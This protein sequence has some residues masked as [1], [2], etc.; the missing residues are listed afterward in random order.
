MSLTDAQVRQAKSR[1]KSYTLSDSGGLMLLVAPNDAKYWHFRFSWKGK[2]PRISF[3]RY[4]QVSLRQARLLRDEARVKLAQGVDP[5][6][7]RTTCRRKGNDDGTFAAL[8]KR[9][10]T[11][12]SPRWTDAPKGTAWQVQLYLDKDILPKLGQL[13]LAEIGR[14]EVLAVLRQIEAREALNIASKVRGWLND[15]FRFAV[16]EGTIGFNPAADLDV[17]AMPEP[18]VR[19]NP[20]LRSDELPEFLRKLRVAKVRDYTRCAIELLLLTGVRT[21]ELRQATIDQFD[22][23]GQLWTVPVEAVKQLRLLQRKADHVIPPYLVPL[24][25]QAAAMVRELHTLTGGYRL[26]LPGRDDPRKPISNGTVNMA[27]KRMGY[28]RRL[29][30]HGIRSTLSTALNEMRDAEGRRRYDPDWIE[31]QLSHAGEN[32][33]R[34]TYNHAEYVDAR[35]EMMQNWA[36]WLDSLV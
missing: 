26:I 12:K 5:R 10:L 8:A 2:Q 31:A 13:A 17:V 29:T 25:R 30:G 4:P 19:N 33:I 15:M 24:S 36:D 11:F 14:P 6:T 3:G 9:W 7:G 21:G 22:L 18:P 28:H 34:K 20:F 16:V 27:L 32:K 23:D 35:R 1:T